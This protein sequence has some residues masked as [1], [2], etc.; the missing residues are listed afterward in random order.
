[1]KKLLALIGVLG[2]ASFLFQASAQ[3]TDAFQ[4]KMTQIADKFPQEKL[5]IQTDRNNYGAGE[6]IW[7]KMYSTIDIANK[8]SVLSNVAYVE[9]I[10]PSG[11]VT[12]QKINSLFSGV[13]VGDITLSDTLVEGSYRMRAYT[14]WMRNSSSDYY[15]EKVLNIGNLRAD[16]IISS[17]Q[18]ISEGE[19]EYYLLQFKNPNNAEWKKSSVSYAVLNGEEVIDRGRETMQPD[20]TIKIKVTDK[21]R[22]KPI[23]LRFKNVDESTVKKLINTNIFNKENSVQYF[24][25][26]GQ[27]VGN[28]VNRIAFKTLNPKGLGIKAQITIVTPNGETAAT[29]E[30]NEL[31]MGSVSSYFA[32]GKKFKIVTKFEDGTEQTMDMS[33]IP[34]SSISIALN[35]T[36]PDKFFVQA[37]ISEDRINSEEIYLAV[38]HLGTI[39]YMSKNKANKT[40]VLFT[41]PKENLPTG[42][43]TVSLLNKDFLPISERPMFN[44]SASSLMQNEI[45]LDKQSYG[46][47]EKVNTEIEVGNPGDSLRYAAMSASVV[48]MKNYKDDV[49]N[50]VSILS[51][52]YLNA[53]IKGFIE[54]PSFYFN[55]DGTIKATDLDNLLLTQGWRK[56]N[57]NKLDSIDAS[58]PKYPAEKGL[59]ISG[60]INKVGRK[61]GIPNSK[62]QLI[63]TNN[64]MDFIDTVT[65]SEGHFS[66]DNLLFPDSVKFLI[67]ARNQKGK[68][69]VDIIEDKPVRPEINFDKSAPLILNDINKLNEDQLLANKKF[70]DQL[71]RKGIMDKVFQIE[72]VTVRAQRPKASERSSNLNGPGNADQIITAEELSTCATLEMCLNGRLMGVFFQNGVPMNTRGNVPMQVVIDGMYVESDMLSMIN[73][74]DVQSVEVLRNTNFTAIYGSFGG[75]GV[76]IITSKT[77]RDAQRSSFQ[78][79]GIL[80]ITPKGI[81]I[82]K[83]FYKPVYDV[84]SDKQFQNDLRTTIHWEPGIV[85]DKDGKAKF[86]FFTSDEAGTYRM[87][88]EGIDFQ[89]KILRKIINFDVK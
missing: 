5:H 30:T 6:T 42:V 34:T 4:T 46:L 65:N 12:S 70:Y 8:I 67:S 18:L 33:D 38:Q 32:T 21:N 9:L 11:E 1:M 10:S 41:V 25:E 63:S 52:L 81:S 75:G 40:N 36:N 13:A 88:I 37:N 49:P 74:Q 35:N 20:G 55:E 62:V 76:I 61:T 73:P 24:P 58:T 50:S 27:I 80:S 2:L 31:G 29:L 72:E 19:N 66:F 15:F 59:T 85:A 69:F 84:S 56:I 23:S 17:T 16:N 22:G 54:K 3:S 78:P 68:N 82:S 86:D 7:Y 64:F 57:L 71:E 51:S 89:G 87:I 28:E 47:R 83:E 77:G 60:N 43:L 45:K 14:N 48:N 44:Y 39:F 26:G 53:D 79:T